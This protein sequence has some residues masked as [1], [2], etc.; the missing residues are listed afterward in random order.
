MT[1]EDSNLQH[2]QI[3]EDLFRFKIRVLLLF[4]FCDIY[5][6]TLL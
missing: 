6:F 3:N 5:C 4:T 2:L 1:D